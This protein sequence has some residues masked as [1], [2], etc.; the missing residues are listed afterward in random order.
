MAFRTTE[1]AELQGG[2]T[3]QGTLNVPTGSLSNSNWSTSSSDRLAATKVVAT[4]PFTVSTDPAVVVGAGRSY[5]MHRARGAGTIV[6]FS[7]SIT[8]APTGGDYAYAIDLQKLA[9]GGGAYGS[10]STVLSST[11]TINSSTAANTKVSATLSAADYVADDQFK[12]VITRSGSTG[13][14][15]YGIL[16]DAH[17]QEAPE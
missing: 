5:L 17:V 12:I 4:I 10:Y 11:I 7:A 1:H 2:A 6:Q 15:G 3:I 9:N 14:E 8:T 16:I 13:T